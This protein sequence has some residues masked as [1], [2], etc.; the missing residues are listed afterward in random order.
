MPKKAGAR[1]SPADVS[2]KEGINRKDWEKHKAEIGDDDPRLVQLAFEVIRRDPA[3]WI[4]HF[5]F[6]SDQHD[7]KQ[8]VKLF[9]MSRGYF[10]PIIHTLLRDKVLFVAKSRQMMM[11]WLACALVL[12]KARFFEHSEC[13]V[14]CVNEAA[15]NYFVQTRIK[16]IYENLPDWQKSKGAVFRHCGMRI[17]EV[18][19]FIEGVPSGSDKARGRVPSMFVADELAFQ[20]EGDRSVAA[21]LPAIAGDSL[22]L[23]ISTP[24]MKNHFYRR[25]FPQGKE[26]IERTRPI[27]ESPMTEIRRYDGQSVL[28]LHYTADPMKRSAEWIEAEKARN[29]LGA[30]RGE[31][32]WRQE[33]ELD[34]EVTGRPRLYPN[35]DP[36]VHEQE[37]EYNPFRPVIRGWDF[38]FERPA[39]VFM[40]ENDRNQIV[41]LWA[42]LGCG[43]ARK[44]SSRVSTTAEH[45]SLS[46]RITAITPEPNERTQARP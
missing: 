35:Y 24:N 10:R 33:Y 30:G 34:F 13:Y 12:W 19:S 37:V 21:V 46:T 39:C 42:I 16:T 23:G 20:E 2:I 7:D 44:I 22:F 3:W 45:I 25:A 27:G 15:A 1:I 14:Q 17:P 38:G 8:R 9:P 29:Q 41:L 5:V 36:L 18:D 32:S 4:E 6:T 11:S 26:I 31:E 43:I 28:L 40:Q